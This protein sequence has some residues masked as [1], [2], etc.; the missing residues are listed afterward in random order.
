MK[1]TAVGGRAAGGYDAGTAGV[2]TCGAA[3]PAAGAAAAAPPAVAYAF[4]SADATLDTWR[5]CRAR[6]Q[7]HMYASGC[8]KMRLLL[9]APLPD[10]Q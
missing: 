4:L 9:A 10:Q 1:G 5:T 7:T 6:S 8:Y 3:A 2:T